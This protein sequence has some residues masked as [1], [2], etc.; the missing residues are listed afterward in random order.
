MVLS[1]R[2]L[3]VWLVIAL[4][5]FATRAQAVQPSDKLLPN[6]VKGYVSCPSLE[7]LETKFNATQ[8]GH[9]VNDPA[10]APF[11]E[12]FRDQIRERLDKTGFK[13]G[14]KWQDLEG[15]DTGEIALAVIQPNPADKTSHAT[16][17]IVDITG[18]DAQAQALLTKIDGNLAARKATKSVQKVEGV[19]ITTLTLAPKAGETSSTSV[20]HFIHQEQLVICDHNAT[21]T[22]ILAR[23]G[24]NATDSLS[25]LIP[26]TQIVA[27][28]VAEQADLKPQLKWFVD[29]FGYAEVSRSIAAGPKRRGRDMLKILAGQ[30]FSA[31]QGIGGQI[32]LSTESEELLHHTFVYAP[33]VARKADDKSQD[34]YNLAMRMLS[35]PNHEQLAPQSWVP[36]DSVSYMTFQW[37]LQDA[38]KHSET[39][40]DAIF[41]DPGTFKEMLQG[42]K[43]DPDGPQVDVQKDLVQ[44]LGER[45]SIVT[46]VR[47]PIT[48]KSE[49]M[50]VAIEISNNEAVMKTVNKAFKADPQAKLRDFEGHE[51]WE[52]INQQNDENEPQL[53]IEGE[54]SGFVAVEEEISSESEDKPL[55]PNMAVTVFEGHL[56]VGTHVDFVE[57]VIKNA[58][59]DKHVI[60]NSDYQLVTKALDRLKGDTNSFRF[61]S[62]TD[63]AYRATYELL[64]QGKL[65]EAETM[66]ARMLNA[67]MS[68]EEE[69]EVRKQQIDGSK[70]PEFES[71]Q[72][73]L[74]PAGFF[75]KSEDDGWLVTGCLLK[76][77]S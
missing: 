54:D 73:Y 38:F 68:P 71:V 46:D 41:G 66:F 1:A 53:T 34:K 67:V 7:V 29:P 35:F 61:F 69:G 27:K 49:R 33:A 2:W 52:I 51:I 55:L 4:S 70:L 45:V 21:T 44:Y 75:I 10:M 56:I 50:L 36:A 25:T 17:L 19:T 16:V 20:Q 37:K 5:S 76:R 47:L 77:G 3:K 18:K 28:T 72:K 31:L 59:A 9:L 42:L 58:K 22:A 57:E 62:R 13:L 63:E 6:T 39:L 74:G 14:I 65:P 30:G 48:T 15:V 8:L 43:Q 11:V 32:Y 26:Y 12:D 60:D 23:F 40:V 24:G 64:R